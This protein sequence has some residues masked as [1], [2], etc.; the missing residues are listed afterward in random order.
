MQT[1]LR[2]LPTDR[3][4]AIRGALIPPRRAPG[5]LLLV[6]A[7]CA[8]TLQT[9]AQAV[10][11]KSPTPHAPDDAEDVLKV[12]AEEVRVP[13]AAFDEAG[14]FD[15]ALSAADLLVREDGEAQKVTGVYR[16]PAYVLILA[17]TGGEQNPLKTARLT[18]DVAA[19]LVSALR[20]EGHVALMQ[21]S[22]RAE[23]IRGWSRD[24]PELVRA[25][26]TKLLSGKRSA[27]AE[28][29]M[30]AAD[31]LQ[32]AP[33]GNRHLVVISDGLD[34]GGGA[35]DAGEALKRLAASGVTVHVI[36]YTSLGRKARRPPA[37]RP[38]VKNSLPEEA[39]WSVPHTRPPGDPRPDLRETLEAKGGGV[40]DLDRLLRRGG[41]TKKQLERR[42]EEFRGLAEE[43][44]GGLWLPSTPG[45]MV[46]QALEVAREVDSQYVVTYRPRRPLAEAAAGEYRRLDVITRRVGL[47]VRSRRGYV[48][49][50]P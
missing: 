26:R 10:P 48:A 12:S 17:D 28:G 2:H 20:P 23:L 29:F 49:R 31:Y 14:R 7:L 33:A 45:E 27:L 9:A 30:S 18:G 16:V 15:P 32:R 41:E 4:P 25:V 8:F 37:T 46:E 47:R 35:A 6:F 5:L 42:E 40:L 34:S 3:G 21:V 24:R 36:S 38:R 13:V 11:E 43:T 50:L 22:G 19:A 1:N 39:I 44:G